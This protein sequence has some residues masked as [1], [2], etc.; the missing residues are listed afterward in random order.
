MF[1]VLIS[2]FTHAL[3]VLVPVTFVGVLYNLFIY[4]RLGHGKERL[5]RGDLA[6][7]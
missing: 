7:V 6:L 1:V 5:Q 4:V 3:W 2:G